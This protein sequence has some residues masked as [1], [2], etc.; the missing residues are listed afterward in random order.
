MQAMDTTGQMAPQLEQLAQAV[1][2]MA[3]SGVAGQQESAMQMQQLM[4]QLTRKRRRVPVRDMNGDIL[5]VREVDDD[6]DE[7]LPGAQAAM[8]GS[9]PD[10][11]SAVSGAGPQIQM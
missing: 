6:E 3:Q 8:N 10:L 2:Q 1:S 5:E 9:A 11:P 4:R 7:L